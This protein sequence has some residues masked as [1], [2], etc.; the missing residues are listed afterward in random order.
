MVIVKVVEVYIAGSINTPDK[1][2]LYVP[3]LAVFVVYTAT[4]KG[5][6]V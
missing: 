2:K 3:I 4:W 5:D 1:K 6:V